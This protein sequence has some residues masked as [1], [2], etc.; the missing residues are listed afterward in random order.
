MWKEIAVYII[1]AV[2]SLLMM[3]FVVHMFVGGLVIAGVFALLPG[4]LLGNLLWH[5]TWGY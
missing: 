4:R 3:G 5:A 2:S 1:V